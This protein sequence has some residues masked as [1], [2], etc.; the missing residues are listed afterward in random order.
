MEV[1]EYP[2]I[3][4]D[5]LARQ[6]STLLKLARLTRDPKVAASFATKAADLQL[7]SDETPLA[8]DATP[9]APDTQPDR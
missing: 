7:R 5:Y 6:A 9:I 4:R 2:M 3:G 1:C 8:P